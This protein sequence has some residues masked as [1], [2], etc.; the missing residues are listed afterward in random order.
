M[1]G[2]DAIGRGERKLDWP[3]ED[4]WRVDRG[5][6]IAGQRELAGVDG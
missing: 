3:E 6:A 4:R 1:D 5:G 2:R